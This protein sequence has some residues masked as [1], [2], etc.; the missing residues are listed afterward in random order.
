[1]TKTHSVEHWIFTS[2]C[3]SSCEGSMMFVRKGTHPEERSQSS[4]TVTA[5]FQFHGVYGV[6][7]ASV[8]R[9]VPVPILTRPRTCRHL[10]TD[11]VLHELCWHAA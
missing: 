3:L 5:W 9:G 8:S 7:V 1:M 6:L 2:P 11:T 4:V 10:V